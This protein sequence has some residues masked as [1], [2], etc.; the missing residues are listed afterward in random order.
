MTDCFTIINGVSP[1][2]RGPLLYIAAVVF[3]VDTI[4]IRFAF[5][6]ILFLV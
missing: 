4:Q 5:P 1:G 6:W 3:V 2:M